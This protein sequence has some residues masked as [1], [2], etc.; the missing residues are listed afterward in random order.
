MC[1]REVKQ[2]QKSDLNKLKNKLHIH[3][4]TYSLN[5]TVLTDAY[6]KRLNGVTF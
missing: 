4:Y 6:Q 1:S 5:I 2:P 3:L